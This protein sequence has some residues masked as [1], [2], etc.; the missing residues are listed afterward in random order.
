MG[1]RIAICS[2]KKLLNAAYQLELIYGP[3]GDG[4]GEGVIVS[5]GA[6]VSVAVG[7]GV[8]VGTGVKVE[9]GEEVTV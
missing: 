2:Y 7:A 6:N 9:V 8:S 1:G 4:A 3:V 5:V